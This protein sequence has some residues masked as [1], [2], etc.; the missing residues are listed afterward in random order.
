MYSRLFELIRREEVVLFVGAGFSID[1]G[2]PSGDSLRKIIYDDLN[3]SEKEEINEHLQLSEL[4]EEFVQIRGSRNSLIRILKDVYGI[5]PTEISKHQ[6]IKSIPH[7]GNIITTNYDTLFETVYSKNYN[8]VFKDADCS[9]ID[10]LKTNIFKIH[11]DLSAPDSVIITKSD[12]RHYFDINKNTIFWN[13][14]SDLLASNSVLFIGYSFEDDNIISILEKINARLGSNRKEMFLIAPD[15]KDHKKQKLSKFDIKYFDDTADNFSYQLI[16]NIKNHIKNDFDNKRI[17]SE[18][19]T[20][21]CKN[22][23]I[24]PI[25]NLSKYKNE[26]VGVKSTNNQPIK[27]KLTFTVTDKIAQQI[28]KGEF[29]ESKLPIIIIKGN[30]ISAY[31]TLTIPVEDIYN[32]DYRINGINFSHKE[33]IRN[34]YIVK[35]PN[36][37]GELIVKTPENKIFSGIKYEL[38]L[39]KNNLGGTIIGKTLLYKLTIDFNKENS[40]DNTQVSWKTEFNDTYRNTITAKH[41][42]DL[43]I[44]LYDG[45]NFTFY[46]DEFEFN[47]E[48]PDIEVKNKVINDFKR[49]IYY[50]ENIDAIEKLRK[51]RF[52]TYSKFTERNYEFSK[53]VLMYLKK[54]FELIPAK[55]YISSFEFLEDDTFNNSINKNPDDRF[56]LFQTSELRE[57]IVINNFKFK[58]NYKNIIY[59]KCKILECR[60]TESGIFSVDFMNED[61]YIQV[62]YTENAIRQDGLEIKF[63]D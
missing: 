15:W 58:V 42:T 40:S 37:K 7:F 13:K 50:Y 23:T 63:F 38:F 22:Y 3:D 52:N 47:Y 21:F 17:T 9:Y 19:F 56:F 59:T 6:K 20:Q 29:M 33:D 12:Y 44:M 45:G 48:I 27:S 34:L 10:K 28:N 62:S 18:I 61:E 14:I 36:K 43:L 4:T 54:E 46:L 25:V 35:L 49:H 1:A 2:Y 53:I 55:N 39:N 11:G 41:W 32:F 26:V 8:L 16:E 57:P 51:I 24:S 5:V 60:I 31:P 30:D